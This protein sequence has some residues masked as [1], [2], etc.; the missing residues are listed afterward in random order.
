MQ[1]RVLR[2]ERAAMPRRSP[3]ELAYG[4]FDQ[5]VERQILPGIEEGALDRSD[6]VDVVAALR[7]WEQDGTWQ[8]AEADF[9]LGY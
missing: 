3:F 5:F 9:R 1:K 2:I 4:S 6:L 7:T 8:R